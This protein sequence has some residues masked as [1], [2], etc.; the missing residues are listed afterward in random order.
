[1]AFVQTWAALQAHLEPGTTIPNWTVHS[2]VIGEPFKIASISANMVMVDAPGA[3][4]LQSVRR[5]DVEAVYERWDDYLRREIPRKTFNPLT[6]ESKYVIS[7]LRWLQDRSG[8]N[9]P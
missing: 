3:I 2:G 9:L 5:T 1:M 8:G 6:R 7:I 4:T